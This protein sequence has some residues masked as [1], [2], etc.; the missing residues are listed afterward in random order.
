M[1][2]ELDKKLREA[3]EKYREHFGESVGMLRNDPPT[4]E[5]FIADI[6]RCI[7]TNTPYEYPKCPKDG[8]L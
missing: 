1:D 8:V 4:P 2:T 3:T 7:E 5:D 6:Y